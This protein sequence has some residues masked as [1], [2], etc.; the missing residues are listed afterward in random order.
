MLLLEAMHCAFPQRSD[1]CK[2]EEGTKWSCDNLDIYII[3]DQLQKH[4]KNGEATPNDKNSCAE[5]ESPSIA[6][7]AGL[8]KKMLYKD[9]Q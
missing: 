1:T 3:V 2:D 6:P 8:R 4:T 5:A 9:S 7:A